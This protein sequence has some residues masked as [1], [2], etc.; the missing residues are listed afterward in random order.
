MSLN[1]PASTQA[2]TIGRKVWLWIDSTEV[3][4]Y[5]I[6]DVKQAL[7]ATVVFVDIDGTVTLDVV[8]HSGDAGI[9]E[10]VPLY[11]YS[12]EIAHGHT[13]EYGCVATWMPYQMKKHKEEAAQTPAAVAA[14][15]HNVGM[16][17]AIDAVDVWKA[18]GVDPAPLTLTDGK[19]V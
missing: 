18:G 6:L 13:H 9:L 15:P 11:D 4:T 3:E 16:A 12:P 10:D 19:D 14:Q 8:D 17:N 5:S 7:D 2:P 1:L